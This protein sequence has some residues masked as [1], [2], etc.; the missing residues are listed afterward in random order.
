MQLV[1][2]V[3]IEYLK[4]EDPQIT[5]F[6]PPMLMIYMVLLFLLG[7]SINIIFIGLLLGC[8][9]RIIGLV[10]NLSGIAVFILYLILVFQPSTF[11]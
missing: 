10:D 2:Q 1:K 7:I 6:G 5:R 4:R 8:L 11:L 9:L 3:F